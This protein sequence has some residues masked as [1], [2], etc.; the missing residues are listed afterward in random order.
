M[1]R[2]GQHGGCP[3]E[4]APA[5][6]PATRATQRRSKHPPGKPRD[7]LRR[8]RHQPKPT[9]GR[10][11]QP[12]NSQGA[13]QRETEMALAAG[14][15]RH[16]QRSFRIRHIVL[17]IVMRPAILRMGSLGPGHWALQ[18]RCQ[19]PD[20]IPQREATCDFRNSLRGLSCTGPNNGV[21]SDLK[22]AGT[23]GLLVEKTTQHP[24]KEQ[25]Q[26]RLSPTRKSSLDRVIQATNAVVIC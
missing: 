12:D 1:R 25:H 19:S 8:A 14:L 23:V 4:R 16:R 3:T 2:Q 11:P 13:R 6:A 15:Q 17:L 10:G 5:H 22:R 20:M 9:I 24:A 21:D 7:P 18:R 26:R